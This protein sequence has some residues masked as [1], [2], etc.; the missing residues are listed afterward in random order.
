MWSRVKG[1]G[2]KEE[3]EGEE[4]VGKAGKRER[5]VGERERKTDG[6]KRGRKESNKREESQ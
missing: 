4:E 2:G 5:K 3:E 1:C 6:E